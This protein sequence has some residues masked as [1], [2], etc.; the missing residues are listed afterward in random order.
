MV[1][2]VGGFGEANYNNHWYR[3][4]QWEYDW[5]FHVRWECMWQWLCKY[6]LW[7]NRLLILEMCVCIHIH[8]HWGIYLP[9][10]IYTKLFCKMI[11]YSTCSTHTFFLVRRV[12]FRHAQKFHMALKESLF[13]MCLCTCAHTIVSVGIILHN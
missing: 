13:S 12:F 10:F 6:H 7:C 9:L 11:F 2:T 1:W 3:H 5:Y 4:V 8:I